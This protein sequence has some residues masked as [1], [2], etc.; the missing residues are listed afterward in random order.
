E[1]RTDEGAFGVL[2]RLVHKAAARLRKIEYWCGAI[3]LGVSYLGDER[4]DSMWWDEST[5]VPRG[6]DTPALIAAA[7][8]LCE[9][10]ARGHK[11]FKVATTL[12]DLVPARSA[13][14]SLFDEDRKGED[15]SAA[16]DEVNAE[17]GAS[18]VYLGAMFG[19]RDAAPTRI[20]F[21]QIPDFD[22]R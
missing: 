14:P 11:P 9:K 2:M 7:V 18:V 1:L 22:K 5:R 16:M 8:Q 19:M 12:S 3:S 21:T 4:G 17:F 20:A 10:R 6:Q 15:I 13:T